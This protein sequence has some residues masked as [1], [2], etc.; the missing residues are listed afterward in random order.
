MNAVVNGRVY[1]I[2][3]AANFTRI[4]TKDVRT[5]LFTVQTN[6]VC[7]LVLTFRRHIVRIGL[8]ALALTVNEVMLVRG[9]VVRIGLTALALAFNEVMLMR[10]IVVRIS[11]TALALAFNEVVLVRRI[12]VGIGFTALALTVNEV[13]LVRGIVV[14]IGLTALG[15]GTVG[16]AM[17]LG[18]FAYLVTLRAA[19]VLRAG[20]ISPAMLTLCIV[21]LSIIRLC[22]GGIAI[23]C[24]SGGVP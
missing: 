15:T 14:R 7:P 4:P 8:A 21:R 3:K 23:G 24:V 13:M 18:G 12:V 16:E 2:Y 19:S 20:G 9:I 17:S 6:T 10:W 22:V 1:F 5:C 11:L